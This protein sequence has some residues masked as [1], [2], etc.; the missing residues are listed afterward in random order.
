MFSRATAT[1]ILYLVVL[2]QR[3]DYIQSCY[4]NENIMFGR[5]I[6]TTLLCL[7]VLS[8]RHDF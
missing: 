6:A 3:H 2:P 5:A 8:Q 7:V 1:K 4:R